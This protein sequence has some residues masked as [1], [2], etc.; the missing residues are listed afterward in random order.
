MDRSPEQAPPGVVVSE[1]L[2]HYLRVARRRWR[3]IVLIPLVAVGVSLAYGLRAQK[4][5]DATAK[6][7]VNS[8]NQIT[9]LLN[10]SA[11]TTPAD[12]ERDL[13][14][15]V[16]L[17]KTVPIAEAVRNQLG[18]HESDEALLG[19][20]T[21]TLEG[22]TN[23]VDVKVRDADPARGAELANAF[24]TQ[25]V[26]ARE[27]QA[28]RAFQQAA[29]QARTQLA[30][31][32]LA[33]RRGP[34][35]LQLRS[36]LQELEVDS[37]LQT[38]NA[39]LVQPATPAT[40]AASPRLVFDALLAAVLGLVLGGMAAGL[41]ELSDRR[42]KD[43]EQV[44]RITRLPHLASIPR[45]R[46]SRRKR[47]LDATR[48]QTEGYRSL[49]TNLRFFDLGG[50]VKTVMITSPGP[51]AGKTSITLAL[52]STLAEFD[53]RV[54]ALEC[55][56]RRPRFCEYLGLPPSPGLTAVLAGTA[57]WPK[58]VIE[59]GRSARFSVL[60]SGPPPPNPQAVL[61]SPTLPHLLAEL[62]SSWDV[63]LIDTPPLGSVTD[64]VPLVPSVDGIALV[65]RLDHSTRDM[66]RRVCD[67]LED[68]DAPLLGTVL[69]D[70]P[71]RSLSGYYRGASPRTASPPAPGDSHNG[72]TETGRS[73]ARATRGPDSP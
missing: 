29:A 47:P 30:S 53:Q 61:S 2:S 35:G 5:Y 20:V 36:R 14:T 49:A 11:A 12:P 64:A 18:V 26:G 52:A 27:N 46:R 73:V 15:E 16:S 24:V 10:P 31:L 54:L 28:R 1:Q 59:V 25:F 50:K 51:L 70:V 65:I 9:A 56:L 8:S 69:T 23:I 21:T 62:Q 4:E 63:V 13:N 67:V 7:V 34:Q 3:V 43:E 32:S 71:R 38:G 66:V 58:E 68:L 44:S 48:E 6:V 22:T 39:Q 40:S 17:I 60:P 19:K 45:G 37:T 55:D 41:L 57:S 33:Q 72:R 42:V